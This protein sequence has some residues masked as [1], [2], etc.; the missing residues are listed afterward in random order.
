MISS[1]CSGLYSSAISFCKYIE[2][3]SPT[4]PPPAP[5]VDSKSRKNSKKTALDGGTVKK[6]RS[7]EGFSEWI[8]RGVSV[9]EIG[10]SMHTCSR[11]LQ[12]PAEV[13]ASPRVA[14]LR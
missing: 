6:T 1:I 9:V 5:L 3:L 14:N 12:H 2:A 13:H 8:E 7:D 10:K 11:R 4:S